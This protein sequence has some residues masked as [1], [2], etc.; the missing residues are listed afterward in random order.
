MSVIR[1]TII[2]R[3]I[4]IHTVGELLVEG[5]EFDLPASRGILLKKAGRI[6]EQ[7][8]TEPML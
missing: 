1:P 7:G 2:T 5:K 4:Q 6:K 8:Q 3:K